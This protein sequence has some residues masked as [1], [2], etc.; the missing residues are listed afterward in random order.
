[1]PAFPVFPRED[2]GGSDVVCRKPGGL[3][4]RPLPGERARG[5]AAYL[6]GLKATAASTAAAESTMPAPMEY[7]PLGRII[8]S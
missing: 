2:R 3:I 6:C 8:G 5:A 4:P 7:L 1:M